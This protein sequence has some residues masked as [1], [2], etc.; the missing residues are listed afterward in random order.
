MCKRN[1]YRTVTATVALNS[2]NQKVLKKKEKSFSPAYV[3][4]TTSKIKF[5]IGGQRLLPFPVSHYMCIFMPIP[6]KI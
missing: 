4:S 3:L 1:N 2:L 5:K 6:V